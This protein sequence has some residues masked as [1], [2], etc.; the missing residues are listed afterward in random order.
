MRI[1][2]TVLPHMQ[3]PVL[4]DLSCIVEIRVCNLPWCE[5]PHLRVRHF[6]GTIEKSSLHTVAFQVLSDPCHCK[7]RAA[8]PK[9]LVFPCKSMHPDPRSFADGAVHSTCQRKHAG[10]SAYRPRRDDDSGCPRRVAISKQLYVLRFSARIHRQASDCLTESQRTLQ[11]AAWTVETELHTPP[12]THAAAR[13]RILYERPE[14]CCTIPFDISAGQNAF[15]TDASDFLARRDPAEAER[16]SRR[17]IDAEQ[18]I[19]HACRQNGN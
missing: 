14:L 10:R 19:K 13:L 16:C 4:V 6:C 12:S 3:L 18:P 1:D 5:I 8:F 2:G 17:R 11:V 7:L 9:L 15:L